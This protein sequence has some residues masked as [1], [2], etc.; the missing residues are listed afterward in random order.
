MLY[1]DM[2]SQTYT[3]PS[4][5]TRTHNV[6]NLT[7]RALHARSQNFG[8]VFCAARKTEAR[9]WWA[10]GGGLGWGSGDG[11]SI[12]D[13]FPHL[14]MRLG[15]QWVSRCQEDIFI[16]N[17]FEA[18]EGKNMVDGVFFSAD[19]AFLGAIELIQLL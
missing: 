1:I 2:P 16:K 5:H 9:G 6:K 14:S 8:D 10:G 7:R 15:F 4:A 17:L 13:I 18:E 19:G 12:F 11:A 3:H